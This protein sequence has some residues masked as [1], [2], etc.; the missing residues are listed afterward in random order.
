MSQPLLCY[1]ERQN[2]DVKQVMNITVYLGA[3]VGKD[4]IYK[5]KTIEL[6]EWIAANSHILIYGGSNVGLMGVLADKVLERGAKAYGIIPDFLQKREIA[7][8]N[9][10]GLQVV[11]DMDER[12][13][14]MMEEGDALIALPGGPGT[15]EEIS[16]AISWARVGKNPK[17]C[18]LFN[19]DGYYDF[20]RAQFDHMVSQGFLTQTDREKILFSDNLEEIARF[21]AHY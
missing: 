2:G 8:E 12:K 21:I 15:L 14:L 18:I 5:E 16:E 10:T 11:E 19:I 13:A 7:H 4:H 9:L 1:N 6:A 20:L 3:S 17:P